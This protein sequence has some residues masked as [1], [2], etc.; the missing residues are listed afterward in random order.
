MVVDPVLSATWIVATTTPTIAS[1]TLST[2]GRTVGI[3]RA[4]SVM[5]CYAASVP[6]PGTLPFD[7]RRGE[8]RGID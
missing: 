3:A 1:A 4:M 2:I 6:R 7:G 8:D 5:G